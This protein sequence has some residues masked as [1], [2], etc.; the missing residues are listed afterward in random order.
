MSELEGFVLILYMFESNVMNENQN[1]NNLP[2]TLV[3]YSILIC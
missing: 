2:R 3:I 1:N